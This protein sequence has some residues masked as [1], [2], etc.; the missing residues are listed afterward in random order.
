M[1]T[2]KVEVSKMDQEHLGLIRS[3]VSSF[4]ADC[5]RRF[6]GPGRL[7]DVAPQDHKGAAA[8]FRQARIDTLD[9]DPQSGATYIADL[10]RSNDDLL[11]PVV[12]TGSL[13]PRFWSMCWIRLQLCGRCDGC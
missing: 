3:G 4:M 10:C 11:P 1:T 2:G 5:A 6:D 13:V 9:I 8:Y 12:L 7:L